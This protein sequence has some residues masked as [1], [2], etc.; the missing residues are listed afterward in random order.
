M[1]NFRIFSE[2]PLAGR[3]VS[4]CVH[5]LRTITTHFLAV[6]VHEM[7]EFYKGLE[8]RVSGDEFQILLKFEVFNSKFSQNLTSR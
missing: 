8:F 6:H 7:T 3:A 1:Q 2:N 4:A 5:A